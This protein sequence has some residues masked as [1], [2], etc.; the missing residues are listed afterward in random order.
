[1]L[2]NIIFK[3]LTQ[4]FSTHLDI[5]NIVFNMHYGFQQNFHHVFFQHIFNTVF[6]THY[7]FQHSLKFSTRFQ[8]SLKFSTHITVFNT[9]WN[10]HYAFPTC[11]M[12]VLQFLTGTEILTCFFNMFSTV[13]NTH[14]GFKTWWNFQNTFLTYFQHIS[15]MKILNIY[16]KFVTRPIPK[17]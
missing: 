9:C 17:M 1:M 3:R 10:F 2:F 11:Y 13:F 5:F 14:Y 8:H 7:G 15:N 12:Y 16:S 4:T 6:N